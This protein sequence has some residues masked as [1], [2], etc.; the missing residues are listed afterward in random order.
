VFVDA[1]PGE[2]SP[3]WSVSIRLRCRYCKSY[4]IFVS[5]SEGAA[6]L[7]RAAGHIARAALHVLHPGT[8]PGDGVLRKRTTAALARIAPVKGDARI[9][10]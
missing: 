1:V 4:A 10:G 6:R 7:K 2:A 3:L 9:A 8:T 5:E